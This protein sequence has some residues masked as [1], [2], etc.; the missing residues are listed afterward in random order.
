MNEL[1]DIA[2]LR[3]CPHCGLFQT[4]PALRP[5]TV[6]HCPRCNA[7]LGRG[8]RA[9]RDLSLA[10]AAAGLLLF[11]VAAHEPFLNMRVF[12]NG[13]ETLLTSGPRQLDA[14]GMW[15]VGAVVLATTMLAPLARLGAMIWVLVGVRLRKPPRHL[16]SVFRW[17]ERLR[18]WSMV[19]VFMLGVLV[20][21]T[22]LTSMA[23]IQVGPAL[24]A[25]GG[26]MLVMAAADAA[27]APEAVWRALDRRP[28]APADQPLAVGHGAIGCESCGLVSAGAA[29]CPRCGGT[30]HARK[31]DSLSRTWA[32]LLAAAVMYV[33]ANLL[34]VLT[35]IRLGS[36]HPSTILG[37]AIEL[38]HYGLWP[39]AAL[40]FFASIAVPMFKLV[41][42][43][44]MLLA[45]Q[46]GS[47]R[48]LRGRTRLYRMIDFI[49]RWSM[50]DVF[51]TSVLVAI[52]QFGFI[53]SVTPGLGVVC[54]CSVVILTM[55][56][57]FSFDP[58]LMWDAAAQDPAG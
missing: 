36:G 45:V 2:S 34:P 5:S 44:I 46:R 14:E 18:P 35:V 52:V 24:Y 19:E 28:R 54:F 16:A 39:L 7:L 49:G 13:R 55:L 9:P 20:A 1:P 21:Y 6:A 53:S 26:L 51:M 27:L 47:A 33:P 57:A 25:M 23:T 41:G 48:F 56:A 37:G 50:I 3:E 12:G 42:L 40:V 58:R 17:A 43:S 30:L 32:L 38:L 29:A 4:V 10:L 31:P 11:A 22:R 8:R 15:E